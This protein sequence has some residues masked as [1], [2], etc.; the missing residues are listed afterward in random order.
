[1]TKVL[2]SKLSG[3][4]REIFSAKRRSGPSDFVLTR[5]C[6]LA[7]RLRSG[8]APTRRRLLAIRLASGLVSRNGGNYC[9]TTTVRIYSHKLHARCDPAIAAGYAGI[10]EH[11]VGEQAPR[12]FAVG[13]IQ[14]SGPLRRAG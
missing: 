11:D 14:H 2:I 5:G 4:I 10:P 6:K 7:K 9:F 13:E 12:A 8:G 3:V 1:M